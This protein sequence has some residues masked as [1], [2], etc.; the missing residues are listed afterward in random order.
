MLNSLLL[1]GRSSLLQLPSRPEFRAITLR[2]VAVTGA[3]GIL[4]VGDSKHGVAFYI[5]VAAAY[6][7]AVLVL[8]VLMRRQS[9]ER[10]VAGF[11]VMDAVLVACVLYR[12][13]LGAPVT[14]DHSLTTVGLVVPFIVLS[15][16]AMNLDGRLVFAFA[17]T[18]LVA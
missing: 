8:T 9:S 5:A 4:F 2:V 12:D 11:V 1:L 17:V 6:L 14:D 10:L 18:V 16:V 13:L 15:H 3:L 7:A